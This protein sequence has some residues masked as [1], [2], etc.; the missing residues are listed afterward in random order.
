MPSNNR[1]KIIIG[2]FMNERTL[3]RRVRKTRSQLRKCL[4]ILLETKKIQNITVKE[5]AQM[6][7]INRGTFYLHY[8]DV[9]DLMDHIQ[10]DLLKDF[11]DILTTIAPDTDNLVPFIEALF[12][13]IYDNKDMS[14]I[15]IRDDL[16]SNFSNE[17]RNKLQTCVFNKYKSSIKQKNMP[18]FELYYDF[19][20]SG[21]LGLLTRWID[22]DFEM[23]PHD[24][25]VLTLSFIRNGLTN[26]ME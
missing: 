19:I 4:S 15:F 17:L 1:I 7:D 12:V 10:A 16:D 20:L 5:L 11:D 24:L 13:F 22:S 21:T 3:D 23:S 2:G 25:A 26:I 9:Y 8:K 18:Y 14:K 6:A